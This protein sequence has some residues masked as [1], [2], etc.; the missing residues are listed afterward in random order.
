MSYEKPYAGIKVVDMSQG[1]AGP[2]GA[3]LLAQYGATV[4]KVEPLNGDWSRTLG[5]RYGDQ[6]AF[7][8]IGNLGKRS[9]AVDLKA[10]EGQSIVRRLVDEADVFLEGFRPGVVDRLGFGYET[11]STTNPRLLYL[12]VSGFGQEGP[13]RERPATDSVL[14]AFSGF[15]SV[16]K[17]SDGTPHKVNMIVVDMPTALHTFQV[18]S[19]ALFA[20]GREQKGRYLENN[21]MQASAAFQAVNVMQA[22]LEGVDAQSPVT[23]SGTYATS[24]GFINVTILHDHEFPEFCDAMGLSELKG[25]ARYRTND[26]R[27]ANLETLDVALKAAF[28]QVSTQACQ[29]RLTEARI[30]HEKVNNHVDFLEHPQVVQ[31]Q[32][33]QWIDHS[34]IGRIPVAY[35]PGTAPLTSG[36]PSACAPGLG[37]HTTDILLEMGY[38]RD[39]IADLAGREVVGCQPVGDDNK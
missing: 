7:S 12:S 34:P 3:M 24:N 35:V 8:I 15:M 37:E 5:K 29:R 20:R 36:Q 11:V 27:F 26:Q 33:I 23:P 32:G 22:A 19:A 16:N 17:G 39:A 28:A 18:L 4:I 31:T 10:A 21:L 1:I 38:D 30:L 2:Y 6:T 13:L 14:Q 9:L 25:D